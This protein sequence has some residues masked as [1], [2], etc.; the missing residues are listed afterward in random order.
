MNFSLPPHLFSD[1]MVT[2]I[3]GSIAILLLCGAVKV[4]DF[5]TGK[6]D[7]EEELKKGNMAVATVMSAYMLG[8]AYIIGQVVSS[9]MGR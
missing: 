9:V 8:V 6:I 3:F 2:L 4:W 5:M 1:A 7:E